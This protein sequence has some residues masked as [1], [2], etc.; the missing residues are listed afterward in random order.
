M[1]DRSQTANLFSEHAQEADELARAADAV[2][3]P[4]ASPIAD[5]VDAL[6][7]SPSTTAPPRARS[8]RPCPNG[9]GW[10]GA[11]RPRSRIAARKPA[12]SH[13]AFPGRLRAAAP[14]H[15]YANTGGRH[16]ASSAQL[17][18]APQA[19]HMALADTTAA[20]PADAPAQERS[21]PAR[22]F[23]AGRY[24]PRRRR[25]RPFRSRPLRALSRPQLQ[26]SNPNSSPSPR[27]S[28]GGLPE[29][30]AAGAEPRSQFHI[31]DGR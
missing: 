6:D 10:R 15:A 29:Y 31:Q 7:V 21:A 5:P 30:G 18:R 3:P 17:R 16:S 28:R 23:G 11:V 1:L 27:S 13:P 22:T 25:Y 8:R 20:A 26:R 24:P 9:G 2:E 19:H 4:A 12:L 14:P